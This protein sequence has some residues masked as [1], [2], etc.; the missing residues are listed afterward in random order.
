ME[1][2]N[3]H[4]ITP[5]SYW[6]SQEPTV[7]FQA[8]HRSLGNRKVYEIH[9]KTAYESKLLKTEFRVVK[10]IGSLNLTKV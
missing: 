1:I 4:Q 6:I 2:T 8:H 7:L 3:T 5:Q 9:T 10:H